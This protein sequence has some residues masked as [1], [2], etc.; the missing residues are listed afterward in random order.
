MAGYI[1]KIENFDD[2]IEQWPSYIERLEQYF[3]VNEISNEKRVP[4]L[5]SLIGGKTYAL[6]RNL[7][8]P[9]KTK[10]KSYADIV[11]V[12]KE[13]L[14]PAPLEIAERYRFHKRDQRDSESIH[15]YVAQLRKLS[16]HCNFPDLNN[17]LRDRIV[18]G[19][20]SEQIQKKLLS[21]QGLTLEKAVQISVAMETA[22]KDAM[23]L[24]GKQSEAAVHKLKF[25]RPKQ[26]FQQP[27]PKE[28]KIKGSFTCYR[29]NKPG[30]RANDCL[31]K[32]QTCHKCKKK[33]HIQAACR[34]NP[35]N[36]KVF[37]LDTE[38]DET[39]D[40]E[41]GIYTVYIDSN[42]VGKYSVNLE[43]SKRSNVGIY[44]VKSTSQ[45]ITVEVSMENQCV[46][47]EVDTGSAVSIIPKK[48]FD[49][50]FP[51]RKLEGTDIILRT[52]SG[53]K[54]KPLG[55]LNVQVKYNTQKD[56]LPLYV[57]Q[58]GGAILFG[59]DWL[60]KI[61]LDWNSINKVSV[62]NIKT[63]TK[64][65]MDKHKSVFRDEIGCVKDIKGNLVLQENAH[66]VF[67]KA[68]P[69]PYAI[70][71]K[72]EEELDRLENEG[73]ISK[74]ATSEWGT[75][76]VPVVKRSGG[77]RIC[78][79]FKVTINQQLQVDQYPLPRIEDIF[80]TLSGGERFSK[81]DLTQAYLQLQMNEE[82]KKYL[83][84]NTHKGLY[85]YNRLLFGVASAPAI[86]QRTIEQILQ[87]LPRVQ[88]ILDDMVITGRDD[89]EHLENLDKVLQRLEEFNVTV[90]K[91]KCRFFEK[92]IEFCGHIIDKHGLH[93]TQDKIK[94]IL[95]MPEPENV[96]QVRQYLG[97]INFYHKFLPNIA[98]VVHP[99]HKLL[100]KDHKWDW[101]AECRK[102]FNESKKLVTSDQ[103][104]C[105]YDPN[106][107]IRLA[108]DASPFAL[109][110]VLSH[111]MKDGAERPIA[112]ASRSLS[113]TERNY[114]QIDKEALGIVF[115]V[116]KFNSYLYGRKFTLITDHQPLVSIFNPRKGISTTSAVRLQKHALFLSGYMYDIQYRSTHKHTNADTLS[117]IQQKF[118]K[119][120]ED[121][122]DEVDVFMLKQLEQ[123][124][125]TSDNIRL[126]T[127]RDKT[128]SKVYSLLQK[129]WSLNS[130]K[131]LTP[132]FSRRNEL[133]IVQGCIQWGIR[134]IIP[135][136]YRQQTLQIL[137]SAH[138]GVVKMKLLA[139]S[140]VWW[141]SIDSDIETLARSCAGCQKHQRNPKQAPLHPWEWP[142]TPWK[143]I[144]IDFAGPFMDHMF[145]IAVDAHSKWPEVVP[146]KGTSATQTIKVLRTIFARTG[147]PEQIVSDNGPQFV[148][149]EFQNFTK[150]NGITHIKSAP[151]HPATNGLAERFVFTFKQSMKAM[152]GENSDINK[153]LANFL[154]AYRNTVHSTTN[155]TPAKLFL[156]RQLRNRLDLLKPDITRQV[157]D[158]QM[159]AAIKPT[160]ET[161]REFY[162]GDSVSVRDYRGENKWT[163]GLIS[164]REGP[165]NYQVETPSGGIWNRHADQ[166][167]KSDFYDK[168][169]D[170]SNDNIEP[171]V[172]T[173]NIE[174]EQNDNAMPNT[175]TKE[176]SVPPRRYPLRIRKP[177][178]KFNI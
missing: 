125:L 166:I 14:S 26:K 127:T 68:R 171:D 90:N 97:L 58:K 122:C 170:E 80:A 60:R 106:L 153:K 159:K 117:R 78:G 11:K 1:G 3:A 66:P 165:L 92:E 121:D 133:S 8:T 147:L 45:E 95:D 146:M 22:T 143:R 63:E 131:E 69:V 149:A 84:I 37:S 6:L 2:S 144:H 59:R 94:A 36:K 20:K 24:Q 25:S 142:S 76:I 13:H 16:E 9:D 72:V 145:L 41:A 162:E 33:G 108:C 129:G 178:V 123:V 51:N 74:V 85:Q 81:I 115:G 150:M 114:S 126:E 7:T 160:K 31:C 27:R 4:A 10:D 135:A 128:L 107:P 132:Y 163:S 46:K 141:P 50:L 154:L 77:V 32:H 116:K 167:R 168:P 71:P 67:M 18:C 118:V 42:D 17:T 15:E 34:S 152:K 30:H 151:Y 49:K 100:E 62:E 174:N 113:K 161:M 96:T 130:E 101:N 64:R 110:A 56:V 88:C 176:E 134:T 57:V 140:Y 39:Q 61:R 48:E 91:D 120:E 43:D 104:L 83:T 87:G 112:F 102:A 136:K 5:L 53:E 177:V 137:H 21:V 93:K 19:L 119:S 169:R 158:K 52:F 98:T 12:L 54:L 172:I 75:P 105:H 38:Y 82:S 139:R 65:L 79:D 47:M 156:G 175:Y 148:S 29:C 40:D 86:W 73:I 111:V 138:P 124:C 55:V 157:H 155:E 70:K 89:K 28:S 44:T 173:E 164:K 35:G 103:V 109:G 23:E 99:L